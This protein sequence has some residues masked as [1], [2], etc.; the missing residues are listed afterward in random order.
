MRDSLKL[1]NTEWEFDVLCSCFHIIHSSVWQ[2]QNYYL[3]GAHHNCNNVKF[4]HADHTVV[5]QRNTPTYDRRLLMAAKQT[6][7]F[8]FP[9]GQTYENFLILCLLSIFLGIILGVKGG[10]C[11]RLT[12]SPPPVSWLSRKC[13]SLDI[14]QPYGPPWPVT[15]IALPFLGNKLKNCWKKPHALKM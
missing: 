10:R 5:S 8:H 2:D 3:K 14:S 1:R 15:G 11:M 6:T 4:N 7:T 12:T 13:G 9:F